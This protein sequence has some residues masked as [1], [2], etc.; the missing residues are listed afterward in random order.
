MSITRARISMMRDTSILTERNRY[1]TSRSDGLFTS[2]SIL[3]IDRISSPR[4]KIVGISSNL[5]FSALRELTRL[6]KAC[7]NLQDAFTCL[8]STSYQGVGK[9]GWSISGQEERSDAI[10]LLLHRSKVVTWSP[11]ISMGPVT[12]VLVQVHIVLNTLVFP[13][14]HAVCR[15][16]A[17]KVPFATSWCRSDIFQRW[18]QLSVLISE[19]V[20]R[21]LLGVK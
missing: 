4:G 11:Q 3:S 15:A 1:L 19:A 14:L 8:T 16:Y 6:F 21:P 18:R 13:A 20:G 10:L 17:C 9:R 2:V 7:E 12:A 5:G